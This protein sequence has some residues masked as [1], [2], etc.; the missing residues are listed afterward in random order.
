MGEV[1][2][3]HEAGTCDE[4]WVLHVSDESLNSTLET[5]TAQY[6][7]TLK[8]RFKKKKKKRNGTNALFSCCFSFSLKDQDSTWGR[9]PP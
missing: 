4:H 6:G 7:N 3:E 2:D 9:E 5:D 8:F 1:G